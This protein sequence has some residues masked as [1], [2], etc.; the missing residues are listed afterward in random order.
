MDAR[1]DADGDSGAGREEISACSNEDSVADV[2]SGGGISIVWGGAD[3]M[4]E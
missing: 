3:C 1:R 4:S 2:V